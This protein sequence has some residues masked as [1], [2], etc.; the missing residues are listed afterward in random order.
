MDGIMY[1]VSLIVIAIMAFSFNR[2]NNSFLMIF[3]LL[4]GVYI[5]YSHETGHTATEFKNNMVQSIDESARDFS[6]QTV[7]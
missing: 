3:V 6:E 5:I 7:K 1:P 2:N 4:V